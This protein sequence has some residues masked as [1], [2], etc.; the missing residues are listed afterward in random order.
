MLSVVGQLEQE[1]ERKLSQSFW[2]NTCQR[3]T[4]CQKHQKERNPEMPNKTNPDH[5]KFPGGVEVIDITKH[6]DFMTGNIV[7]YA[8]RAGRKAGE[9]RLDDLLKAK[10]YIDKEIENCHIQAKQ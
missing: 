5:Y 3:K 7:K 4:N 10:W 6:L 9:S 8:A 1:R 2:M